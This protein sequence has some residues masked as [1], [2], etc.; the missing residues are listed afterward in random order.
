MKKEIIYV[1]VKGIVTAQAYYEG[2]VRAEGE[3]VTYKGGL[4]AAGGLPLWFKP[5]DENYLENFLKERA[6]AKKAPAVAAAPALAPLPG[7]APIKPV[8]AAPVKKS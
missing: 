1:N 3:V 7:L 8:K 2:Q 4:N 5:D 6:N